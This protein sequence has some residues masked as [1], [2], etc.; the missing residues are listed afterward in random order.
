MK[1]TPL[2]L[3]LILNMFFWAGNFHAVKIAL[4]VYDDAR[5]IAAFRFILGTVVLTGFLLGWTKKSLY[6]SFS[7]REWWHL[8]LTAFTGIFIGMY[9]FNLG[10]QTTSAI[11]GSL[12]VATGPTIVAI[13]S[14]FFLHIKINFLQWLAIAISFFGVAIVLVNGD[15]QQ[16]LAL[17][18]V[19]G[20]VYILLMATGFAVSQIIISKYLTH[21]PP[22]TTTLITC[23]MGSG[24][25]LLFSFPEMVETEMPTATSFWASIIFMGVLGTGVAYMIYYYC[26]VQLG[27]TTSTL[28]LNLIPLFTVLLAFFFGEPLLIAQLVGGSITIFGLLLFRYAGRARRL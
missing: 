24:L 15:L 17:Q 4:E 7:K 22:L 16:L 18:F 8:F 9:F 21:I 10:L 27:A 25:F 13:L 19:I 6:F 1:K 26:I 23:A 11:N 12:I 5:G 28:F 3:L 20:D 2:Y 14:Y